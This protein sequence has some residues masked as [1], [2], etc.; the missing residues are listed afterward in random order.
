MY[1]NYIP[2]K[3]QIKFKMNRSSTENSDNDTSSDD[4]SLAY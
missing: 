4:S 1:F 3:I 2:L